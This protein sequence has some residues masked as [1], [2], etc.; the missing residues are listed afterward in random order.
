MLDLWPWNAGSGGPS[1]PMRARMRT[2]KSRAG[3]L[4]G[5]ALCPQSTWRRWIWSGE[6]KPGGGRFSPGRC[7]EDQTGVVGF[8]GG[9]GLRDAIDA[10]LY[11]ISLLHTCQGR[12][13]GRALCGALARLKNKVTP[14]WLFGRCGPIPRSPFTSTWGCRSRPEDDRDWRRSARGSSLRHHAQPSGPG[15]D[16][17]D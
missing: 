5:P 2:C 1:R 4:P 11:A 10:E 3:G 14:P 16:I 9:G 13:A 12:G 17:V 8:A 7:T 6:R 15:P